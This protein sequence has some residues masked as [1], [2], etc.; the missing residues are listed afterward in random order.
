MGDPILS[1]LMF[2]ALFL[3]IFLGLP[4]AFS[5]I[6]VS[7]GFG[8]LF[9]GPTIASQAF[10]FL[11]SITT[12]YTLAAIPM[13]IFMGAMLERSSVAERLYEVMSL[14]FR[15]VRGGLALATVAMCALF[16]AGTGIVGA[17]EALVGLM[18]IPA[19]MRAGYDK[20]L[21]AGTICAGGSLG[22]II[23]PSIVV[24]IYANSANLSIGK[25]M[26]GIILPGALMVMLFLGYIYLRA[27][28][29]PESAPPR[30]VTGQEPGGLALLRMTLA[31][32]IPPILLVVSTIGAILA[33]IASPTEAA[34]IGALGTVL[35]ALAYRTFTWRR[36]YE[37]LRQTVGINCMVLLIVA[38]GTMF[39]SIFRV[40]GGQQLIT[41][42]VQSSD[43]S[44]ALV[45]AFLL[46]LIFILGALLDWVSVV[47]I[48]IPIFLPILTQF[49]ID[50]LWFGV[51]AIVVIQTSYLTP[52]M[53]PAIFYL[54]SIAP[55][56][57]GYAHM[58][59]GVLPFILC[60]LVVLAIVAA[61][62][63]TAT[64]LPD[65][66]VGF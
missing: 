29:R 12:N 39:T 5:L 65:R 28:L 17:V 46:L 44:P 42:I 38:G 52:P 20:G 1:A 27:R 36:F 13:F 32:L 22:T 15:R 40:L 33:G 8:Y 51:M 26:A 60:Q 63:G 43:M 4:V 45:T 31:A 30:R 24:V 66:I 59:R 9:F 56:E 23:P 37:A 7:F 49:G 48:T 11:D 2:P 50:P 25:V 54:R 18:A 57:M 35:L 58:Y 41:G 62:P 16:A 64:W 21:I 55:P 14:L 34:G 47:L 53:A 6:V 3:L 61:L 19:M 10:R